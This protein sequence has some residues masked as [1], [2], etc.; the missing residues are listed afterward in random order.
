MKIL[1]LLLTVFVCLSVFSGDAFAVKIGYNGRTTT[2]HEHASCKTLRTMCL[3][4]HG[5]A[6]CKILYDAAIKEGGNWATP[7]AQ[8]SAKVDETKTDIGTKNVGCQVD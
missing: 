8:A 1:L 6:T 2:S 4:H 5:D 3:A 7:A